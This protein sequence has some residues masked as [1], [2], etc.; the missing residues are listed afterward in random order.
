MKEEKEIVKTEDVKAP[1]DPKPEPTHAT[2]SLQMC[3]AILD[4]LGT[5]QYKDVYQ[6]IGELVSEINASV[7][8]K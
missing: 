5:G 3:N 4:Y 6:L 1:E 7:E 8:V 2:I